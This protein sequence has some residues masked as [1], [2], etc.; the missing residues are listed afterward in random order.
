RR[1]VWGPIPGDSAAASTTSNS[2]APRRKR[3]SRWGDRD[4]AAP[5]EEK[6]LMLMPDSIVLSNGIKVVLPPV[7][8]GRSPTGDPEVLSLHQT[9]LDVT[10][11]LAGPLE[12]PP[13]GERSPSPPPIYD[14]MGIR[15]NTREVRL[16][17]KLTRER[18]RLIEQLLMR[19]PTYKAPTDYRPEKKS[20]KLI[21]PQKE[22]P[23]YNF[24]G[25]IIGPRGATQQRMQAETNTKIAIRGRGSV[26]EGL[27]RDAKTAEDDELHVMITGDRQEDVDAAA[28]MVSRLLEP[29]DEEMNEHKRL[30]LRE[31][32]RINGTLK[33]SEFCHVCGDPGH[34]GHLCPRQQQDIYRLPAQ[35]AVA[36]EEQY[37]RDVARMNPGD[38]GGLGGEQA[39]GAFMAELGGADPRD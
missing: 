23:G 9:L 19:D 31:L 38:A 22:H 15:Q 29:L 2:S 12:L 26:K 25:L 10:R 17:E 6:A 37:A 34:P 7:L 13:E 4:D 30:Q 32:A 3:K 27:T 21:I 1:H 36:A 8:T 20:K 18:G 24:I 14:T 11:K 35:L 33:E 28:A 5:N 39:F 16:K